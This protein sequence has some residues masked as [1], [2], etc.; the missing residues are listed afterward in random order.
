MQK[1][2]LQ[3]LKATMG[4]T[5]KHIDFSGKIGDSYYNL[6]KYLY[7]EILKRLPPNSRNLRILD[8]GCG[9]GYLSVLIK[10]W[11]NCDV[12][13]IDL[14]ASYFDLKHF[15]HEKIVAKKCDVEKESFPFGNDFFDYT[16]CSEV[17]E[18]LRYSPFNMLREVHR[19]LRKRGR[20]ILTT[21]NLVTLARRIHFLFGK[22]TIYEPF[23]DWYPPRTLQHAREFT[24]EELKQLLTEHGFEVEKA[25]YTNWNEKNMCEEAKNLGESLVGKMY[26]LAT[27]LYP[28]FKAS[29]LIE[30]EALK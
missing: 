5:Y 30:A 6:C 12:Y 16:V 18:H 23:H 19:T 25:A 24:M 22:Q 3:S 14:D 28:P 17:L 7:L 26:F 15:E 1:A 9:Y 2:E 4:D 29:M 10:R 11:C 27:A 8:V 20:L 21:P 13:A